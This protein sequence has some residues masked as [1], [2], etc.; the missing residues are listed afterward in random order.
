MWH[1]PLFAA[2]R[3]RLRAALLIGIVE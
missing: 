3:V 2:G 1:E